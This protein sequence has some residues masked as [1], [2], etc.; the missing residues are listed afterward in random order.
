MGER[1]GKDVKSKRREKQCGAW[2]EKGKPKREGVGMKKG[3]WGNGGEVNWKRKVRGERRTHEGQKREREE[4]EAV[5]EKLNLR[6]EG[7]EREKKEWRMKQ[8]GKVG[9]TNVC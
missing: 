9:K 3:E 4:D 8:E 1:S 2:K 5:K 6:S 7:W